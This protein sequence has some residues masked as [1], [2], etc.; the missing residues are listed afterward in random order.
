MRTREAAI[1]L[2]C[3]GSLVLADPSPPGLINYQGVLRDSD[4]APLSGEF[5]MTFRF[6]AAV[7][8]CCTRHGPG[9]SDPVCEAIVCGNDP[10]CCNVLWDNL[11]KGQ[12]LETPECI[13]CCTENELLSDAHSGLKKV[14]VTGGLFNTTLG[15]G[16]V[17][18][19][20]GP[21]VYSSLGD[22][23]RKNAE[24]YLEVS[25]ENET[26]SP[27]TRVLSAAYAIGDHRPDPPC[28]GGPGNVDRFVDCGNGTVTD[29]A[30]G[31][32]W[33]QDAGCLEATWWVA[34]TLA[35]GLADGQCG[36]G[37]GSSP[38]DWRLPTREEWQAIVDQ[39]NANSCMAPFYP[40]THGLGCCSGSCAFDDVQSASYWASSTIAA[41][42]DF[43]W[44]ANLATGMVSFAGK[45]SVKFVWAVRRPG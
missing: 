16:A 40:D 3:G 45:S 36:L 27:R 41:S 17:A 2:L 30:T 26:L 7:C 39:A 14:A 13:A 6:F 19:G 8:D 38:G 25:V 24:V 28:H 20:A 9:C 42:P 35:K 4:G 32:V 12:A 43:A 23:F 33:L 29:T 44:S 21:G 10:F 22:V 37:D 1:I 18:D 31:L 5:T 15:D 11:C 34:N